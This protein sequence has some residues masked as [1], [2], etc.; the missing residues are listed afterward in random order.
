MYKMVGYADKHIA[1][2]LKQKGAKLV[3]S[4]TFF[5][6]GKEGPLIAGERER[7]ELWAKTILNQ[8]NRERGESET[9]QK[10]DLK[11]AKPKYWGNRNDNNFLY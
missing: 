7:A 1:N 4:A 6:E 10:T 3:G 8:V 5:V 9:L 2:S 11:V